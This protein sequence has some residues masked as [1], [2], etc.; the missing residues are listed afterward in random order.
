MNIEAG[1][2]SLR[3]M[4][5]VAIGAI[6]TGIAWQAVIGTIEESKAEVSI[7]KRAVE[8]NQ[9]KVDKLGMVICLETAESAA[10]CRHLGLMQ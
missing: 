9:S 1:T 3:T 10:R 2:V 8:Q 6:G 4:V 5:I 7:I